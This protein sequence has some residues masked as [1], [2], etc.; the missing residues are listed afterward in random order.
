MTNFDEEYHRIYTSKQEADKA[1]H[2]LKGILLGINLDGEVNEKEINELDKW[3]IAHKNLIR[4]N[5]FKE[6]MTLIESIIENQIPTK[7]IIEDLWWL[8][9]KYEGDNQYY[10][11][12]TTD[13]QILH[14]LCHGILADGII[15][16]TE[17]LE[18]KKWLKKHKHLVNHYP[19]DELNSLL[20]SV[21]ADGV[22]DENE[23]KILMAYFKQF[24]NIQDE[25]INMQI[26]EEILNVPISGICTTDINVVFENKKFCITGVM[27]R[28]PRKT[29][30]NEILRLGG[31]PVENV[32]ED[33]DYLI[34]G[35]NG[36][37]AWAFSCY[38]RKVDKALTLRKKGR[39]IAI[40][41]EY[42]FCDILDDSK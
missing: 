28:S 11:F 39:N 18:L 2:S 8:T 37:L 15:Q 24:A 38:G 26:N 4:K 32:T 13:I 3:V 23:R 36:N 10:N 5:P 7:E 25:K 20:L 27:K 33:T 16:D 12:V 21:L 9:Q 34:V 19:Y 30:H 22:I 29:M 41:H 17:I 6:F 35:D 40:I 42:D 14:G 1:I 31:I